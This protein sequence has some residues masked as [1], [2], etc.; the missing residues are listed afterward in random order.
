MDSGIEFLRRL[1]SG[2]HLALTSSSLRWLGPKGKTEREVAL[3]SEPSAPPL[4]HGEQ[5]FVPM[6]DGTL[7]G[8]APGGSAALYARLGFSPLSAPVLDAGRGQLLAVAGEGQ[9]CAVALTSGS[10]ALQPSAPGR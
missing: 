4:L 3:E 6:A 10:A 2:G 7:L 5:A 9:L 8:V 1:S